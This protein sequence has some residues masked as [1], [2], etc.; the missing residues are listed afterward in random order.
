MLQPPVSP[1]IGV[2]QLGFFETKTLMM[3]KKPKLKSGNSKD[4]KKGFE[5][6]S[7]TG[8]QKTEKILMKKTFA[9]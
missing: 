7:K 2:S 5:R 9:I 8:N 6:I 4:K 1:K 3:K